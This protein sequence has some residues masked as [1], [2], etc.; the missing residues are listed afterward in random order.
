MGDSRFGYNNDFVS[1]IEKENVGFLAVNFEYISGKT[2]MQTY[3]EVIG[4]SLPFTEVKAALA[5]RGGEVDAFALSETDPL[6]TKIEA[7]AKEGLIDQGIG[8]I[9]VRQANGS[10][11]RMPLAQDRRITGISGLE[12]DRYLMATGAAVSVFKKTAKLG[13]DDRLGDRIIGSFQ[14]CSGGT[15]PW[16]TILSAEENFQDQ[17][18]EPVMADGSSMDPSATPFVLTDDKVDGRG[19]PFGLAGNKYGWMVEVDPA[20]AQDYGTKHT[21]LGRYRHEAVAV[22]AVAG[23]KLAVYSGCDRRGGHLYK[24]VSTART[25]KVTDPEN[26]KLLEQG[27]LY[28]A[29]LNPDGTGEWIALNPDT[30]V[31]PVLPS[32]VLGEEAGLVTFPNPDRQAGGMV[33]VTRDEDAIALQDTFKTL[34]DLYVGSATDKQGA[35]LIDAHFAANAAGVTCLA[36]PEDTTVN[37]QGALFVAFTSGE[38]GS[39]GGPDKQ[40]F[41]SPEGEAPYEYGW[42][43]KLEEDKSDPGAM[44]FRWEMIALGGEPAEGGLGFSNPDNLEIDGQGNLWMVTDIST[45]KHNAEITSRTED[46]EPVGLSKLRGLFGNNSAWVIPASGPDAGKAVPFAVGPME[47]ELCGLH[48]SSDQKALFLATQHPGEMGGMR[49]NMASETRQLVMRTTDGQEFMQQRQVPI[50]SNWPGKTAQDPPKPALVVVQRED[51]G[52]LA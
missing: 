40:I 8:V 52:Q 6:K 7:I 9:S 1:L 25:S 13:Y 50:G 21:W 20:N 17:V 48:I 49:Q 29:K 36:R 24:F 30:A 38:P 14:N 4:A 33:E 23:K 35:I 43:M 5:N 11:E 28:G 45:S 46:G 19:N 32:Q 3:P 16:G 22:R 12:D 18:P 10:W 26:S 34:G 42:I 2:W 41:V 51:G 15:T 44:G 47:C 31:N 37:E 27:M 39:D